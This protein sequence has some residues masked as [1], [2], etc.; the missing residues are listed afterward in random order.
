MMCVCVLTM[1]DVCV[2]VCLYGTVLPIFLEVI[3]F[4]LVA[5]AVFVRY[6]PVAISRQQVRIMHTNTHTYTQTHITRTSFIHHSYITHITTH[7]S[8]THTHTHTH[9]HIHTH[10]KTQGWFR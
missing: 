10:T 2:C 4:G 8:L 6:N 5:N 3:V 9:T 7:T 1:Y